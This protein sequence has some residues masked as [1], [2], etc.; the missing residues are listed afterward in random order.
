[1]Q[2]RLHNSTGRKVIDGEL[3]KLYSQTNDSFIVA[4]L[5]EFGIIGSVSGTI[6]VGQVGYINLIGTPG[7][8]AYEIAVD[9]GFVGD[10]Q[11]WLASLKNVR[12]ANGKD[13]INGTNGYT[14]IKDVDYFDGAKGDKGDKG[15][16]GNQGLQGLPGNDG[17]Q[18]LKGDQGIQGIPGN[19]GYTPVKNIDYF[20]GLK[21]DKGDKGDTGNQGIQGLPGNDGAAG[22]KGDQGIQGIQGVPGQDGSDASVTK[23]NVETVLTGVIS[24][25]SHA[26]GGADPWTVIKL[27]SDFVTSLATNTN[28]TNF[29]FTPQ[30]SKTYLIFGYFL[31]RTATATIGA[32][33]GVAWPSNLTDATMRIEAANAL[34]TS[35]LTVIRGKDN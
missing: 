15:D 1:M 5:G 6:E 35:V 21:G 30:A 27:A 20:D 32:R 13:G 7:K 2:V 29:F 12:G 34:T 10:K 31:L 22:T 9:T 28:V 18:G 14:P 25:H 11:K 8:S 26:G 24:S 17:S 4:K 16:T 3:V 19:S 23:A 33:P